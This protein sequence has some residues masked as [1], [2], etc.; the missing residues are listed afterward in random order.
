[1][2]VI[3]TQTLGARPAKE[4][5]KI[6]FRPLD[7]WEAGRNAVL[8]GDTEAKGAARGA[9]VATEEGDKKVQ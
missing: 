9:R 1:M 6:I 5:R 4:I 3:I 2:H 8:V 7:L